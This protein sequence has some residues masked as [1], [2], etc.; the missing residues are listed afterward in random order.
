ME[1]FDETK[2]SRFIQVADADNDEM[3]ILVKG[4]YTRSWKL[5]SL[6]AIFVKGAFVDK[7]ENNTRYLTATIQTIVWMDPDNDEARSLID[8]YCEQQTEQNNSQELPE[9]PNNNF[10]GL[11]HYEQA[12]H[13]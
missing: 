11:D 1:D 8:N 4:D 9:Q 7:T 2:H 3:R 5:T 10:E 6:K 12:D 13:E